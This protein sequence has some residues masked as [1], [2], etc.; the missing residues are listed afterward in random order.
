MEFR[1]IFI[2]N[3]A[4]VCI[5]KNCLIIEQE[6]KT[7]FPLEDV[8]SV[9]IESGQVSITSYT[10]QKMCE[11]GIVMFVC[12]SKHMPGGYICPMNCYHRQKKLIH[13]QINL[14]KPLA[15]QL[16]KDII[17]RKIQNQ[18][19]C[20]EILGISGYERLY[21]ISNNVLSGDTA[22]SEAGA[23][24]VYFRLLFG[25][26]FTR[27]AD[28]ISNAALDYGYA[29]LRGFVARNLVVHGLEP[30]LGIHHHSE[31]NNFNLAD[32]IIEPFRPIV[33]LTV[34]STG[35]SGEEL[36]PWM[37]QS[38]FN[39]SN[40]MMRMEDKVF[41]VSMAIEECVTSL[42][43]SILNE[44]NQISLPELIKLEEYRYD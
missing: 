7:S 23:A 43:Q 44:K 15:K 35:F 17:T 27:G 32:D 10:L 19:K 8:A 42:A 22:N 13:K 34:A 25:K 1:N 24:A 14:S 33:D 3:Q 9:L 26:G 16:W 39:I 4:K 12:D 28:N 5:E 21:E 2:A 36:L 31:L 38:L 29:I 37:K 30:C 6:K 11:Y 41:K 20:L 40:Y 18:A